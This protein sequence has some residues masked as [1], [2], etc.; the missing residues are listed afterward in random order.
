MENRVFQPTDHPP[1]ST[2]VTFLARDFLLVSGGMNSRYVCS[3]GHTLN[4]DAL[5]KGAISRHVKSN[6]H[7]SN[8][9]SQKNSRPI[10]SFFSAASSILMGQIPDVAGE[11]LLLP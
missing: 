10:K 6:L 8:I 1:G 5:N 7:D 2:C 9:Q 3:C 11:G 4:C